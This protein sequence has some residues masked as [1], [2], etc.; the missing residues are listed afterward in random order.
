MRNRVKILLSALLLSS[1]LCLPAPAAADSIGTPVNCG[2]DQFW[3]GPDLVLAS[4]GQA[5]FKTTETGWTRLPAPTDWTHLDVT[6]SGRIYLYDE[7]TTLIYRSDDGGET[8]WTRGG[9][10][11][12]CY[13]PSFYPSPVADEVFL[14]INSS[15]SIY[16]TSFSG[17][18]K[19]VDGGIRWQHVFDLSHELVYLSSM[20]FSPTYVQDGAA[21]IAKNGRGTFAGVW[22]ST[23]FGQ[24]WF[25]SST[26]P[27]GGPAAAPGW[28]VISPQFPQDGTVFSG[29]GPY[30]AGFYKSTDGGEH[31]F[32]TAPVDN[33]A[34]MALS[35]DY[36]LDQ[37]LLIASRGKVYKSLN[38]AASVFEIWAPS[39]KWAEV[40][41]ISYASPDAGASTAE[42]QTRRLVYWAMARTD[43]G[44]RLYGSLNDGASWQPQT[45]YKPVYLPAILT[46]SAPAHVGSN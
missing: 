44:C 29:N 28:L 33:V 26:E 11:F 38:G 42:S 22:K 13:H 35:P 5:L 43:S 7:D 46:S 40:V 32:Y 6:S 17:L 2:A 14:S 8:W 19:S 41:G 18:W 1:M 12:L 10:P 15:W 31:W 34:S 36:R 25:R 20:T 24:T 3:F 16:N 45:L 37:T 21:F 27:I 30:D 39:D 23:D 9:T 4:S